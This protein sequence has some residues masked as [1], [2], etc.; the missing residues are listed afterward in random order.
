MIDILCRRPDNY[1]DIVRESLVFHKKLRIV[2]LYNFFNPEVNKV[3]S[4]QEVEN[5][6]Y[7]IQKIHV[8]DQSGCDRL[9][10]IVDNYIIPNIQR[11]NFG[12]SLYY[13]EFKPRGGIEK[14]DALVKPKSFHP[15]SGFR[16]SSFYVAR[17]TRKWINPWYYYN[18]CY[19]RLKLRN[20]GVF[21]MEKYSWKPYDFPHFRPELDR[22]KLLECLLE[23]PLSLRF[24]KDLSSSVTL[25]YG[26]PLYISRKIGL[27]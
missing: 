27:I 25:E 1:R 19:G 24:I 15:L 21:K 22:D 9:K 11:Q 18:E 14:F 23:N 13:L 7:N 4:E 16:F 20:V 12:S 17:L 8:K 26:I 3:L 2:D 6:R 5:I 10:E